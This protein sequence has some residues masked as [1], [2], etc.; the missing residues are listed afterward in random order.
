VTSKPILVET[1]ER[2]LYVTLNRPEKRNALSR[3]LLGE[4]RS[5]FET[6]AADQTLAAAVL[7]AA[8]DKSFA[9]G[10][11]LGDLDGLRSEQDGR[12]MALLARGALD[13][14]RR[15]PVPVIAALNGDALGGGAELSVSCD[16]RV[17]SPL[18]RIGFIQ[19]RLAISTAWGGGIDLFE[20]LGR[21]PALRLLCT[22]RRAG[23]SFRSRA[24]SSPTA[25]RAGSGRSASTRASAPP[26]SR[27]SA[28][29]SCS[30]RARPGCR[31]RSTCPRSAGYDPTDR[32]PVRRSARSACRC[33]T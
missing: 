30:T 6:H 18:A 17:A 33:P 25:F 10:G 11:D 13:A 15:F 21:R 22:D 19:G 3:S 4:I 1:R 24:A 31:W 28:T 12:D 5:A 23:S 8:G 9:A 27:T 14:V 20:L 2:I 16:F 7:R 32:W 29:V 26:R